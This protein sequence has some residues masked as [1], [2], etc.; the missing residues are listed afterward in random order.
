[1]GFEPLRNPIARKTVA[2]LFTLQQAADDDVPDCV[3]QCGNDTTRSK[4]DEAANDDG[5]PTHAIRE[6]AERYLQPGLGE[7]VSPDC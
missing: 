6:C 1:M 4:H 2:R 3:A 5:H 7:A